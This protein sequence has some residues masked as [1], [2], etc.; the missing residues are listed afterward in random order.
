MLLFSFN[1]DAG[2]HYSGPMLGNQKVCRGYVLTALL[3]IHYCYPLFSF[4]FSI[5]LEDP[6]K[7][8]AFPAREKEEMLD[9]RDSVLNCIHTKAFLAPIKTAYVKAL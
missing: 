1:E 3:F 9:F 6:L 7:T 5:A 8:S 4:D 2:S